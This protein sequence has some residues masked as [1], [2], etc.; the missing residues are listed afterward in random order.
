MTTLLFP[1]NT[2]LINFVVMG[3]VDVLDKIAGSGRSAWC[4]TVAVECRKSSKVDGLHDLVRMNDIFGDPLYPET[5]VEHLAVAMFR[6]RLASPGD[7]PHKHLGEAETLAIL[8]NRDDLSGAFVTDD[9]DATR[10]ARYEGVAVYDTF[11]LLKLAFRTNLMGSREI[12]TCVETLRRKGRKVRAELSTE[13][14]VEYWL[15]H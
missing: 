15:Y 1:D 6:T 14:K 2:V 13:A 11:D 8:V 4:A 5:A 9:A 7:E 3:R 10:L 12:W